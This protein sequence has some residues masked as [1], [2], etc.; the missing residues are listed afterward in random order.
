MIGV[1]IFNASGYSCDL[2]VKDRSREMKQKKKRKGES[3]VEEAFSTKKVAEQSP[4]RVQAVNNALLLI[5]HASPAIISHTKKTN[6][7]F[8]FI[9]TDQITSFV[10]LVPESSRCFVKL[11]F[12]ERDCIEPG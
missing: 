10:I 3:A 2:N 7:L 8:F 1:C 4:V 12:M 6:V 11:S 9:T 5:P